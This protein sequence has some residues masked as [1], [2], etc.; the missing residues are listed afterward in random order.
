MKIQINKKPVKQVIKDRPVIFGIQIKNKAVMRFLKNRPAVIG[1]ILIIIFIILA[2]GAPL[3]SPYDPIKVNLA[4]T[5]KPPSL[6]HWL[7]TDSLGRDILSRLIY[8]T[9]LSFYTGIMSVL[10]SLAIGVPIGIIAGFRRRKFEAVSMW[11]IDLLL[12]FPA[13]L[14]SIL[15]VAVLGASLDNAIIAVGI[16]N[17]PLFARL[18]RSSALVVTQQDYVQAARALGQRDSKIMVSHVLMNCLAPIVVQVTIR[19]AV[20][21]LTTAGLS[22]LGLGAEFPLPEWGAMLNEGRE[23]LRLAP[24][25]T[26]FPGIFLMLFVFAFNMFGDGINDAL[27]ARSNTSL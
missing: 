19:I 13:M 10:I 20:A 8:G 21:T 9:R 5:C 4:Y 2:I 25:L 12:S 16:S 27:N 7:G 11:I 14:L 24:H 22:F 23:F 17:I 18:A 1:L 15:I 6:Q 3:F 26:L